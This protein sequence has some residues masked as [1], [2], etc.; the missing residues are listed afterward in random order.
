M[1]DYKSNGAKNEGCFRKEEP[2]EPD[3]ILFHGDPAVPTR[4]G[5]VL[6]QAGGGPAFHRAIECRD[7]RVMDG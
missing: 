4:G 2:C 5:I 7:E 6:P 1:D 3:R